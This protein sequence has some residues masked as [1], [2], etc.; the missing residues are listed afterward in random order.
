M[1]AESCREWQESLG[2]YALDNLPADERAGLQAHLEGCAACRT[3]LDSLTSVA[4]LL[5][6]AD[7]ARFESTPAPDPALGGAG[8]CRDRVRAARGAGGA[9]A[10]GLVSRSAPPSQPRRAVL[11]ILV[12]PGG[13]ESPPEQHVTFASLPSGMEISANL[14]PHA[15]GTEIHIVYVQGAPSG[16]LCR[17][18]VRARDGSRLPGGVLPLPLGRR[19]ECRPQRRPTI[20][21]ARR[22]LASVLGRSDV[23]RSRD[24]SRAGGGPDPRNTGGSQHDQAPAED[25]RVWRSPPPHWSALVAA[26]CVA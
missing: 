21:L 1:K 18:F 20:S 17:V 8:R 19:F 13:G 15:F 10:S 14:I 2:A 26:G 3:E 25:R 22:R 24:R 11:A 5:P 23:R 7:P 6:L 16:A 12:L 4:A 9:G